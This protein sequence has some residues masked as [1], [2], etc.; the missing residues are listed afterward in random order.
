M[1]GSLSAT[2]G[3]RENNETLHL[4]AYSLASIGS[5]T[6]VGDTELHFR[7]GSTEQLLGPSL[8]CAFWTYAQTSWLVLQSFWDAGP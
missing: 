7:T 1:R 3:H 2:P 8:F 5:P 6:A 4:S